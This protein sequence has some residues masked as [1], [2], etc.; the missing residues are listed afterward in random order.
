MHFEELEYKYRADSVKL[1]D[2]KALMGSLP[3]LKTVSAASWDVYYV[4]GKK[5]DSFQRHR[6]DKERPE[7]TKKLKK[8]DSNNWIRV[9]S[10]LPL[11]SRRA[12]EAVVS[13]H[14][15]LDGYRENF[16][17]FKS[18]DIY[19]EEFLNYVYYIVFDENM[20]EVG[21]FIEVEVNK[22]KVAE[23]E[24]QGTGRSM[25][26]LRRGELLL[27]SLGITAQN[28]LKKS[29]FELYRKVI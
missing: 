11:D 12:S 3:I 7:L 17:I 2:F 23:L 14:V 9:E 19:F 10:D 8:K 13:F 28:R 25:A 6:M 22:D 21:R 26:E 16:R 20:R 5:G 1:K 27:E 18:C 15:G 24:A 29:L 4:Q